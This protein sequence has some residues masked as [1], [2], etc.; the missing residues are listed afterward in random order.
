MPMS[1][2][3]QGNP[4]NT[5]PVVFYDASCKLCQ[6]FKALLDR[7]SANIVFSDINSDSLPAQLAAL[8][9]R[10]EIHL[11]EP[12]GTVLKNVDAIA[13]A[14]EYSGKFKVLWKLLRTPGLRSFARGFYR[15][16]AKWRV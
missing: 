5:K 11:L 3:L 4:G 14:L 6:N 12:N 10:R 8:N 13:R 16:V 2:S 15:V 9:L 7:T 1:D